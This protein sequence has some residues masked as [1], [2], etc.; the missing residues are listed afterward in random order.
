MTGDAPTR[1]SISFLPS[2]SA[3]ASAS[4]VAS[5]CVSV[6]QVGLRWPVPRGIPVIPKTADPRRMLENLDVIGFAL[7][8]AEIAEIAKLDTGRSQF[9]WW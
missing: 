8:D 6:A 5:G 7:S 9:G 2:R 4:C 3:H 1:T